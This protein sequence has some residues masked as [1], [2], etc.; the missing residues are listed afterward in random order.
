MPNFYFRVSDFSPSRKEGKEAE[1]V[2][3][4]KTMGGV[5]AGDK[6]TLRIPDWPETPAGIVHAGFRSPLHT[7]AMTLSLHKSTGLGQPHPTTGEALST[8]AFEMKIHST[9]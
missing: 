5:E 1:E 9:S 6:M 2:I 3:P 8:C 7:P 4:V